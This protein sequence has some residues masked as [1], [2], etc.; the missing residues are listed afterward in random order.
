MLD[1][2]SINLNRLLVFNAVVEAGSLTAAGQ[3]LGLANTMVSRH[4]QLLESEIGVSLLTRSTRRLTLT[5]A[6]RG[7]YEASRAIAQSAEQAVQLARTGLDRPR[8]TLRVAAAIDYG[9]LVVTPVLARLRAR[10]PELK[11][12]LICGD[13]LIDVVAE[14]IDVAV[15]IGKLADSSLRAVEVGGFVKSLVASPDFIAAHGMPANAA[16]LAETPYIEMSLLPQPL[17]VALENAQR[18]KLTVR[19]NKPVFSTNT[20]TACRAAAL[21]GQGVALMTDFAAATDIASGKLV[22]VMPEWATARGPIHALFPTG[23]QLQQK[24]RVLIDALKADGAAP[25]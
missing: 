8:G 21:A 20:A 24:V 18:K 19:M 3:R 14:G 7:F 23:A 12:E 15:R 1:L 16:Q 5:E 11:V 25:G 6:G 17:T 9:T 13:D 10:Y 2:H 22:R 4:M